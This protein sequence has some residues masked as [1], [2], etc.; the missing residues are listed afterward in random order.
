MSFKPSA[1]SGSLHRTVI[2]L[3]RTASAFTVTELA[4]A[5]AE[6]TMWKQTC[7]LRFSLYRC[8]ISHKE[9]GS[10]NGGRHSLFHNTN[11]TQ[12]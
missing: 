4:Q 8:P 7:H 11:V 12:I 1:L 9:G 2:S 6:V 10:R 3:R 5:N